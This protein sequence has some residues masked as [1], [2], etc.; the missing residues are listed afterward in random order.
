MLDHRRSWFQVLPAALW[1][2][3]HFAWSDTLSGR[4]IGIAD[5]D[6]V[7]ILD[8]GNQQHKIRLAGIDAPE[9]AQPY[10]DRSKTNLSAM[11]F[12]RDVSLDCRKQDRYR[13]D[14]CIVRVDGRD[15]NLEQIKAGMAWWYQKYA[16]DQTPKEREDYAVA[17]FQ[18]KARRAGLW[19]DK[20]PVAPWE[21]RHPIEHH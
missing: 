8:A 16:K 5:G 12:G 4:V 14:V 3:S 1:I 13:R 18:A 11:V 15:V 10:G 19:G 6:T 21:W 9:K 7:T 17:E 2:V 20:N